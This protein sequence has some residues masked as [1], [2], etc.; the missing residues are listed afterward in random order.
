MCK[1]QRNYSDATHCTI[2]QRTAREWEK[3]ETSGTSSLRGTG[4]IQT[5]RGRIVAHPAGFGR[6]PGRIASS[7]W[8]IERSDIRGCWPSLLPF[9]KPRKDEATGRPWICMSIDWRRTRRG[10]TPV[11]TRREW[12]TIGFGLIRSCWHYRI[13]V[14]LAITLSVNWRLCFVHCGS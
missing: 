5:G 3:M 8:R 1:Y 9:G 6:Q 11:E 4:S 2:L 14:F 10:S 7:W 13:L 12:R